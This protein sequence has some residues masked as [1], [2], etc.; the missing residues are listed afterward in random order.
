MFKRPDMNIV[1]NGI[2]ALF[3]MLSF[4]VLWSQLRDAR[5]SFTKDQR[6]YPWL[7][8]GSKSDPP[9]LMGINSA[10]PNT[11]RQIW[12][13][14]Y[15]TN[16]GKSPAIEL[17]QSFDIYVGANAYQ[18]V[19]ARPLLPAKT[20]LPTG[21]VDLITPVSPKLS[22]EEISEAMSTDRGIII[23]ARW[24]YLD[25]TGHRYET[26]ICMAR[27]RTNVWA[28]CPEHNQFRDCEEEA[29]EK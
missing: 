20:I 18:R 14:M 24:Q 5:E 13:N 10:T 12:V 8:S 26:E 16:Y 28:Y 4:I 29:C 17:Q 23:D 21:K 2:L 27:L 1:I 22:E 7:W 19:K 15:Y 11:A 25:L 9:I 3:A 6:P